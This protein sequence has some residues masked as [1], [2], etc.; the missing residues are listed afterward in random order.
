MG[1]PVTITFGPSTEVVAFNIDFSTGYSNFGTF[2]TTTFPQSCY[3]SLW[4][5]HTPMLLPNG[6]QALTQGCAATECCPDGHYYTEDLEWMTKYYSPEPACPSDYNT[7]SPP[8]I[9]TFPTLSSFNGETIAFCCPSAYSCPVFQIGSNMNL[10]CQQYTANTNLQVLTFSGIAVQNTTT[11]IIKTLNSGEGLFMVAYPFQIRYGGTANS[12][13]STSSSSSSSSSAAA[14]G[15]SRSGGGGISAGTIAGIVIGA[16]LALAI[17]VFAF[18]FLLYKMRKLKA[19]N[20]ALN[21]QAAA[22]QTTVYDNGYGA[23]WDPKYDPHSS[24]IYHYVPPAELS[25]QAAELV[26]NVPTLE[27]PS[28]AAGP[29]T[30]DTAVGPYATVEPGHDT[31]HHVV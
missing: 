3:N 10:Y 12:S 18:V 26:G 2:H 8:Q 13:S 30:E 17:T 20:A 28:T 4:D 7:C 19:Q 27:L 15:S 31:T 14:G 29:Y 11:T 21:A 16:F 22:P 6:L 25:A 9:Y 1:E 23:G 5:Y 24:G